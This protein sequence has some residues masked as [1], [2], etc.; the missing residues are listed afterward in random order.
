M[1]ETKISRS[2]AYTGRLQHGQSNIKCAHGQVDRERAGF[3]LFDCCTGYDFTVPIHQHLI[4]VI[5]IDIPQA[6]SKLGRRILRLR[7]VHIGGQGFCR[8]FRD[9]YLSLTECFND[10]FP[11]ALNCL[12]GGD[13]P[14]DRE[15]ACKMQFS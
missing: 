8:Y 2:S 12:S 15:T 3:I 6:L 5:E 9:A 7:Q 4:G 10:C 1:P 14:F 13:I 11:G